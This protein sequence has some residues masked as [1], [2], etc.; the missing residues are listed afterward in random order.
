MKESWFH[1]QIIE[2]AEEYALSTWDWIALLIAVI[3]LIIAFISVIVATKTLISQKETQKNTQPVMTIEIQEFLIGQKLLGLLD[4]YIF[5][6]ALQFFLIKYNYRIK[7]SSHFWE[8]I[9]VSLDDME[10]SLFYRDSTKYIAFNHLKSV[11]KDFNSNILGLQI[12]LNNKTTSKDEK[13]ME[14]GHLYA[15]VGTIISAYN[16]VLKI[17]FNRSNEQIKK[18]FEKYFL[19]VHETK[20]YKTYKEA[21]CSEDD[22]LVRLYLKNSECYTSLEIFY[23]EFTETISR[24]ISFDVDNNAFID[25]ISKH[26]DII[27]MNTPFKGEIIPLNVD[28]IDLSNHEFHIDSIDVIMHES[29]GWMSSDSQ[30]EQCLSIK[31]R[32]L[33]RWFFYISEL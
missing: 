21:F 4:S 10:E 33:V 15:N 26:T 2:I 9:K 30:Y 20:Y 27:V 17:C 29:D 6:F 11:L 7:P 23:K 12:V 8:R 25:L 19:F 18:F 13:D 28:N 31:K 1:Q 16:D 3:S 32:P 24:K 14:I 5:L 22:N